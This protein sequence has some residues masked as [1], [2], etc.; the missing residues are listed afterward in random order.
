MK[1]FLEIKQ[2]RFIISAVSKNQ[3]PRGNLR[4][5][6]FV[7]RSNVGKSSL[8]NV[9]VNRR[10][11]AKISSIPGKT[12][13][14]NFFLINE[15]FYFVDLPGYGYA[16]V[17]KSERDSWGEFIESY[18]ANRKQLKC[19]VM[20]VDLRHKPT[21]DDITMYKWINYYNYKAIIVATKMDKI[22]KNQLNK[23]IKIIKS[24][25]NIKGEHKFL[26]FSSLTKQNRD[27]LLNQIQDTVEG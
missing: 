17:S 16:K 7:G 9:L 14:I 26:T 2:A 27:E 8:I 4:E 21:K 18:L 12:R 5:I 3:Y 10:K 20:L 11:L 23:N 25:L 6:A 19:I 13:L 22:S 1:I 15:K 24:T